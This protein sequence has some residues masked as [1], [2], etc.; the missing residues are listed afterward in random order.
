MP[1][2]RFTHASS[3]C[4]FLTLLSISGIDRDLLSGVLLR[5]TT[6]CS[7]RFLIEDKDSIELSILEILLSVDPEKIM[8]PVNR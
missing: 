2:G 1:W 6:L 8:K 5:S 4:L 7:G 3:L